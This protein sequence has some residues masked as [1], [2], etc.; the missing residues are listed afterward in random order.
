MAKLQVVFGHDKTPIDIQISQRK[1]V[2]TDYDIFDIQN[3]YLP[4]YQ[5]LLLPAHEMMEEKTQAALTRSK[6]RDFYDIYFLL[7]SGLLDYK[8]RNQL[9]KVKEILIAKKVRFADELSLFLPRSMKPIADSF[10]K[11]LL[12]ELEKFL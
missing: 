11:A 1:K 5:A 4:T 6:P 7:R 10:P 2:G 12:I 3:E 8:L 9:G